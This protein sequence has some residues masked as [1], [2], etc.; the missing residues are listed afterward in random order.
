MLCYK[1]KMVGSQ[2]KERTALTAKEFAK[3]NYG[4]RQWIIL[5]HIELLV[6]S[7]KMCDLEVTL[8]TVVQGSVNRLCFSSFGICR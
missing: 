4:M 5:L 8:V 1:L 2:L 3:H 6:F 7:T